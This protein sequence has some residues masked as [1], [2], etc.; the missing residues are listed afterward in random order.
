VSQKS[1][2]QRQGDVTIDSNWVITIGMA[3]LFAFIAFL[4]GWSI[5]D[6]LFDKLDHEVLQRARSGWLDALTY[7]LGAVYSFLFAYSFPAKHLKIAFLLLGAKYLVLVAV[8]YLHAGAVV[9]HSAAIAG[10][11]ASQIAYTIILFAIAQWFKTVVRQIPPGD[12]G[13][14]DS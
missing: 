8:S 1:Q 11:I 3:L 14:S 10:A 6:L 2:T 12:H 5:K 13:V 4:L 9:Q 7:V